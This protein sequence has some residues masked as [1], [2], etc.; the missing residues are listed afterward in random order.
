M[1][2]V[3]EAVLKKDKSSSWV[4]PAV[5][6]AAAV[7]A[8]LLLLNRRG[9]EISSVK[10]PDTSNPVVN[11]VAADAGEGLKATG[12]QSSSAGTVGK[13]YDAKHG[14]KAVASE[15]AKT[16]EPAKKVEVIEDETAL[17]DLFDSVTELFEEKEEGK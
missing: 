1:A 7:L 16:A 14:N 4:L 10:A 17:D 15:S 11:T 3:K 2:D 12:L 8:V 5:I 9:G 6:A 13:Q